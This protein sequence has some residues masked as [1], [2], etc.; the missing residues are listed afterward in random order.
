MTFKINIVTLFSTCFSKR[1]E[2]PLVIYIYIRIPKKIML[3]TIIHTLKS[4]RLLLHCYRVIVG[5]PEAKNPN[6]LVYRGGAV[7]RCDF[8]RDNEC[9]VLDFDNS[10]E[11]VLFYPLSASLGVYTYYS[12]IHIARESPAA[13]CRGSH[14][15]LNSFCAAGVR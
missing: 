12:N 3:M 7:Y 4:P 2:N 8:Q 9:T 5:A 11:W 13:A 15:Q 6:S 10:G 1:N 14:L